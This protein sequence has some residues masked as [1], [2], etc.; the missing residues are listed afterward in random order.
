MS[1][2]VITNIWDYG[3]MSIPEKDEVD[4]D[5]H[6]SIN[7]NDVQI[8]DPMDS[9]KSKRSRKIL[10]VIIVIIIILSTIF[11]LD[12]FEIFSETKAEVPKWKE[13]DT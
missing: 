3:P 5:N 11:T 9:R 2:S 10:S 4:N 1:F 13:G 8:K 12:Y 6:Q 7:G